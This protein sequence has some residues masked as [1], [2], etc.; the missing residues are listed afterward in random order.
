MFSQSEGAGVVPLPEGSLE[1]RV[2]AIVA[3]HRNDR[4]PLLPIL[5]AIKEELGYVDPAV[6]PV[7]ATELNLSRADVYGVVTF[8]QDF[9]QTPPGHKTVRICRAEACQAVGAAKVADH[10]RERLGITFGETTLDGAVTLEE[11]FCFGNCATGP[12]VQIDDRLYGRVS[13]E[14]LDN[15][16]EADA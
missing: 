7:V 11:V 13:P 10:T 12:A 9:R 1:D 6:I 14:R 3:E 16:L 15:L 2:R 4:G 8:Y 5:H